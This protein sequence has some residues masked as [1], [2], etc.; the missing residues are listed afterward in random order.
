MVFAAKALPVECDTARVGRLKELDEIVDI[1]C[2]VS[3]VIHDDVDTMPPLAVRVAGDR[4]KGG[5]LRD[6]A[7]P[8]HEDAL[9]MNHRQTAGVVE[10]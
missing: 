2:L 4:S 3:V 1:W 8:A 9:L 10:Q 7:C 5:F 6:W